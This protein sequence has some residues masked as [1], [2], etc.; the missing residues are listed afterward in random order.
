MRFRE[1]FTKALTINFAGTFQKTFI[2]KSKFILTRLVLLVY[3]LQLAGCGMIYEEDAEADGLSSQNNQTLSV[4]SDANT[5]SGIAPLTVDFTALPSGSGTVGSYAW[6]F[7]GDGIYDQDTGTNASASYTYSYASTYQATV[8]VTNDDWSINATD[9]V[10]ISVSTPA[11]QPPT[12]TLSASPISG[13]TPLTVSFS[14]NAS[15]DVSIVSYEW[16]LDGDGNYEQYTGSTYTNAYTYTN[17]GTYTIRVRVTDNDGATA[18]DTVTVTAST[19]PTTTSVTLSWDSPTTNEDG[20]P[21]T[22]LGG[23]RVYYGQYSGTYTESINAGNVTTATIN[24]PVIGVL[25]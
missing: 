4:T 25:Q 22:D 9:S 6:D 19:I 7:D 14:A 8:M 10:T 18:T 2:D 5:T 13:T 17:D 1:V 12:V 20:T 24:E 23:Y 3:A 16:D 21:L 11:N 15:D